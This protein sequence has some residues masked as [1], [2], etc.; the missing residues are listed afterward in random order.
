M[1]GG[2]DRRHE[3]YYE[4]RQ[5][6]N[7]K[8]LEV[9]DHQ[10]SHNTKRQ[11]KTNTYNNCDFIKNS[12]FA[13]QLRF[14]ST[15]TDYKRV[16]MAPQFSVSDHIAYLSSQVDGIIASKKQQTQAIYD[17][18]I[19]LSNLEKMLQEIRETTRRTETN[20]QQDQAIYDT[21]IRL[22]NLEKMLQEILETTRRTETLVREGHKQAFI[23][24]VYNFLEPNQVKTSELLLL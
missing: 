12:H 16:E 23:V 19:R 7:S 2:R 13:D 20:K 4:N 22:S 5:Y 1:A 14:D 10:G 21:N 15:K 8:E 24:A 18:N 17:M 9:V 6:D 3:K 11:M